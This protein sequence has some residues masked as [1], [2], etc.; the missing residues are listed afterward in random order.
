MTFE[1]RWIP[2]NINKVEGHGVAVTDVEFVVNHAARRYPRPIGNEKWLVVG[3]TP[4]GRVIQ[5]IYLADDHET[6]FVIHAR[7]LTT[8]ERR[9]YRSNP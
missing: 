9:R 2:W 1:F 4:A 3:S 7:P 8:K 6:L 5:V